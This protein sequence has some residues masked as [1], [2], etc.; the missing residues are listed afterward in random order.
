MNPIL[1]NVLKN[2]AIMFAV[3]LLLAVAAPAIAELVGEA[4][5]GEAA[6]AHATNTPLLWTGLFFGA[7]GAIHAAVAPALDWAFGQEKPK[8]T[9]PAVAVEKEKTK[10]CCKGHAHGH[11]HHHEHAPDMVEHKQKKFVLV[12]E[13][14]R[15]TEQAPVQE[16]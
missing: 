14:K 8:E 16:R 4:A 6:F 5:L 7:F 2:G 12:L 1:K 11:D 9:A 3:G 10:E 15:G 13:A